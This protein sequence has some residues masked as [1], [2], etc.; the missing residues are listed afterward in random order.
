MSSCQTWSLFRLRVTAEADPGALPR[1][2]QYFHNLNVLPRK[3][4]AEIATTGNVHVEVDVTGLSEDTICLIAA[5]LGQA[6]FI[7]NAYWHRP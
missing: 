2:L 6:P 3:V 5:K 4:L 1:I 7:V